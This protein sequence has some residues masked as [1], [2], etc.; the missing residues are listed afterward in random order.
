MEE[1]QTLSKLGLPLIIKARHVKLA[2]TATVNEADRRQ[3]Y[4]TINY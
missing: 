4:L 1:I 2:L 3:T